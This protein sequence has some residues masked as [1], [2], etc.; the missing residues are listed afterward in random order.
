MKNLKWLILIHVLSA[1]I[2]IGPTYFGHMLF[3]K[4]QTVQELRFSANMSRQLEYFPKI[5]G[6][7]AV[8]SGLALV[9]I[10][11]YGSF[12]QLWLIGSLILYVIIQIVVIGFMAPPVKKLSQ[13]VNDPAN[14]TAVGLPAEQQSWIGTIH[15]MNTIAAVLGTVLFVFMI[16]KPA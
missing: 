10:G 5:G 16:L 8:L 13:W 6:T 7:V 11:N 14:Q 9:I 3:R 1:I 15:S 4:K 12:T 2:G